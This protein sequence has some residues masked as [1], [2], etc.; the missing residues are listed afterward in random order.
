MKTLFVFLIALL[1]AVQ[2]PASP[3]ETPVK[4]AILS[5]S[6]DTVT[7]AD[8]LTVAFSHLDR[9]QLLERAEIERVI[10]E[11]KLSLNNRDYLKLGQILGADGL[12]A[13]QSITEGTNH[14]MRVHLVA[15]RPGVILEDT[16]FGVPEQDATGWADKII[17]YLNPLLPK[18]NVL[19]QAAI[20]LSVV[21]FHA[22]VRTPAAAELEQQIFFLTVERLVRENR[23]FVLERQ[24]MRSLSEEKDL[25]PG[26][27]EPF[28][29]GKYLLDGAIDRA[30]FNPDKLTLNA[31]LIPPG[32][33]PILI[34][35]SGS[36][37]N[38]AEVVNLLA[39]KVLEALKIGSSS[40][41]W[42]TKDEADKFFKEAQ[43]NLAW[44][45]LPQ[46]QA[47]IES[48]WALGKQ[49]EDCASAR[50]RSYLPEISQSLSGY[51]HCE[52]FFSAAHNAA[53]QVVGPLPADAVLD[54]DIAETV[55]GHE[56]G[57]AFKK[58]IEPGSKIVEYVYA[59]SPPDS[60]NLNRA[61]HILELFQNYSRRAYPT[62]GR[63][64]AKLQDSGWYKLGLESL[65]AASEV[66]KQFNLS[67]RAR[68]ANAE[69]VSD[70]RALTR[71]VAEWLGNSSGVRASY[72]VGNRVAT[73]DELTHTVEETS[74]IF[75]C[76]LNWGCFWQE[77]PEDTVAL[78]RQLMASPVFCYLHKDL[79]KRDLL[80]PRLAAWN[81]PDQKRIPTLW[82][83]FTNELATSTNLLLRME[84]K[85][86]AWADTDNEVQKK[87]AYEELRGFVRSHRTELVANKVELFYLGWGLAYP[88]SELDSMDQEYW[89]K[90]ARGTVAETTP[91]AVGVSVGNA[92]VTANSN[93]TPFEAQKA[94]L[95]ALAPF[96]PSKFFDLFFIG[97]KNYTR[98]QALD[99]KPLLAEYKKHLSGR[100]AFV[101]VSQVGNIEAN[102]ERILNPD[103][104]AKTSPSQ[105]PG[106]N[107]TPFHPG[108]N[109]QSGRPPG[110]PFG[111]YP[112]SGQ[113]A[114]GMPFHR[115]DMG[116]SAESAAVAE[117]PAPEPLVAPNIISFKD[118]YPLPLAALP[119]NDTSEL[120]FVDHVMVEGQ[121]VLDFEMLSVYAEKSGYAGVAVFDPAHKS[122]RV[123]IL[124]GVL[125]L[126]TRNVFSHH[127]TL[128][129]GAL[130][131]SNN[132]KVQR[133]NWENKCWDD[134]ALPVQGNCQL[135]ALDGKLYVADNNSIQLITDGAHGTKLLASIQRQPPVS[136][137]DSQ[138]ALINLALFTDTRKSLCAAV[139][140]K[141]FR[142]DG[143]D[144]H[145]IGATL[146]SFTPTVGDEGV[147][148]PTDGFNIKPASLSCFN[149][150]SNTVES[151]LVKSTEQAAH[152]GFIPRP[153]KVNSSPKPLWKLPAE[154]SLPNMS[155]ALW[156]SDLF[157]MADHSE[158]NKIF[159]QEQQV[160]VGCKYLPKDGYH[161]AL[162]CF[163]RDLPA[164]G[165]V[166]LKF[167]VADG[168]PPMGGIGSY[169]F[170][171]QL[172]GAVRPWMLFTDNFLFCGREAGG[173][174]PGNSEASGLKHGIWA[175]PM[176]PIK[177]ELD[178]IKKRQLA[179]MLRQ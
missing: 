17:H 71:A 97:Y 41:A 150:Q 159:D 23:L 87:N 102:L 129:H 15:V 29:N 140:N 90:T 22:G 12:L 54:W 109:F 153:A 146:T 46:A 176:Q 126:E 100:M 83:N 21:N 173:G 117:P 72:F 107:A 75:R 20:P 165:K 65:T 42:N 35:V 38:C 14:F 74:T 160:T 157:L 98:E 131:T 177:T 168:C 78:Y 155:A 94:F 79:W 179:A 158:P 84:A 114:F 40:T 154:L 31:R 5:E 121:L 77:K 61:Q 151:L 4:L 143:G 81:E 125:K 47:A 96:E 145:E 163:Y 162:Y 152:G 60:A 3:S 91:A 76:Q 36:R 115:P 175:I 26:E 113:P 44:G 28:W 57:C 156:H 164:A 2:L 111:S 161:A 88:D 170:P 133:F 178:V 48:A 142:W 6:S 139:H 51:N 16:R 116:H 108:G 149:I 112:Q 148:F 66:L 13:L 89:Q 34:E 11:Q 101:G 37:T 174:L 73:H 106:T 9:V 110:Q 25:A 132:G 27:P 69:K 103:M 118:F 99:I 8:V 138:G 141:I 45:L 80:Q 144:W 43:W 70:L 30:G 50:I 52:H 127:S 119:D 32:G 59:N 122:W 7:A 56:D 166:Q 104:A 147:I 82:E 33:S 53:G 1:A 137:L 120:K 105:P 68:L 169:S 123:A 55:R 128:W 18:L 124:P 19:P 49:D 24:R 63:A 64:Y 135:Y 95:K 136:S 62:D 92:G 58:R 167:D 10:R 86:L 171:I 85:A 67:T 134:N 93:L 39:E 130:L 172:G